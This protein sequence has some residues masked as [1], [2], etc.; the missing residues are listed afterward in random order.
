MTDYRRDML[1]N[2]LGTRAQPAA[3]KDTTDQNNDGDALRLMKR[4]VKVA[5]GEDEGDDDTRDPFVDLGS[6][7][8]AARRIFANYRAASVA[9]A[10]DANSAAIAKFIIGAHRLARPGDAA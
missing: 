7:G 6:I 9:M 4:G 2:L 10:V 3:Y 1:R 8:V 5:N